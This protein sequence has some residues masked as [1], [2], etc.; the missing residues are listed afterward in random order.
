MKDF[1]AEIFNLINEK[2]WDELLEYF[3]EDSFFIFPGSSPLGGTYKGLKELKRFFR[4][5]AIAVPDITFTI[6]NIIGT[7]KF[8]AVQWENK[9]KTRK[10]IDYENQGVT[11]MEIS[12]NK[13][14]S[15]R[16]YLD[17]ERIIASG[18]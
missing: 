3:T 6:I 4:K 8:I 15:M 9:G 12:G 10:K 16:D 18:K 7:E 13:I 17:T 11:I 5:M 1:A 14:I 2:K